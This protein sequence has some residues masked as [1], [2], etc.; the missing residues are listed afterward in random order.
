MT[1]PKSN[2]IDIDKDIFENIDI[3]KDNLE[4]SIL[5]CGFQK[6]NILLSISVRTF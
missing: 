4:I 2:D 3:D 6:K 1:I 5:I